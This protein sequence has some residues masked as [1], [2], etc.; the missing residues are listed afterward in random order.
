ME[1]IVILIAGAVVGTA[2][3]VLAV[4]FVTWKTYSSDTKAIFRTRASKL[5]VEPKKTYHFFE[6]EHT[7]EL[8]VLDKTVTIQFDPKKKGDVT[9]NDP[10]G[11]NGTYK[12]DSSTP[13]ISGLKSSVD[14]GRARDK[15][16]YTVTDGEG[17]R[18]D[19]GLRVKR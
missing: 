14:P 1:T 11:G 19:P 16:E 10:F 6:G 15:W 18:I 9:H 5:V 4:E 17:N 7:F 13:V 12:L 2:V 3:T 8:K